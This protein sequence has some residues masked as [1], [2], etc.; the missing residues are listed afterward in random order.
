MSKVAAAATLLSRGLPLFFMG[1]ESGEDKQFRFGRGVPRLWIWTSTWPMKIAVAFA[2][3]GVS[4]A[5]LRKD[6]SIQGPAPLDVRFEGD[7]LLAFTRGQNADYFVVL[8]FGGW[9]GHKGSPN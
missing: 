2:A 1:A 8:N 4:L 5:W 6:P 9:S 3:G 7:Q